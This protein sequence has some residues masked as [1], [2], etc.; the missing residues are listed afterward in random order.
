M[1]ME[2]IKGKK[3][4]MHKGKKNSIKG[5]TRKSLKSREKEKGNLVKGSIFLHQ[6]YWKML[7]E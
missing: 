2:K 1:V 4:P 5:A 3:N 7:K 6:E